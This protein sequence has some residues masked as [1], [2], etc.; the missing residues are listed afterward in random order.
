MINH[1]GELRNGSSLQWVAEV[2][3]LDLVDQNDFDD[4]VQWNVDF[5]GA[6]AVRPAVWRPV[7]PVAELVRVDIVEL[8]ENRRRWLEDARSGN[9]FGC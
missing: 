3:L 9:K 6:H 5:V 4:G 1:A 8:G 7:V 2:I